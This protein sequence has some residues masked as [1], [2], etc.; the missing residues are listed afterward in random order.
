M[1]R[2]L[3][4]GRTTIEALVVDED[5]ADGRHAI[6]LNVSSTPDSFVLLLSKL[7][8]RE[9]AAFLEELAEPKKSRANAW[10]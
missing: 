10:L 2:K 1:N 7:E 5:E 4:L 6:R 8:A 9:L 3:L